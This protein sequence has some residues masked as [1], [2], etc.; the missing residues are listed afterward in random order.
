MIDEESESLY[1][2]VAFDTD[3]GLYVGAA[4]DAESNAHLHEDRICFD[5]RILRL[6]G[7]RALEQW[8]G[9]LRRR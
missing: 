4:Y 2:Q 5:L 6:D 3:Y 1:A 9:A 7:L 8:T